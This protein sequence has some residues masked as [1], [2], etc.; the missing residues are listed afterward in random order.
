MAILY[1][2]KALLF[3]HRV[4]AFDCEG[5]SSLR[6]C[7]SIFLYPPP[8]PTLTPTLSLHFPDNSSWAVSSRSCLFLSHGGG[9]EQVCRTPVGRHLSDSLCVPAAEWA[10]VLTPGSSSHCFFP[11]YGCETSETHT[12]CVGTDIL[13]GRGSSSVLTWV[14]RALDLIQ[15]FLSPCSVLTLVPTSRW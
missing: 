8:T 15:P 14:E 13:A 5:I 4:V 2:S 3:V 12:E 1:S 9:R 10:W 6:C 7:L 11:S